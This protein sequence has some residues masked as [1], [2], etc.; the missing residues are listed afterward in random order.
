MHSRKVLLGLAVLAITAAAVVVPLSLL[1]SAATVPL[2]GS[3]DGPANPAG[4]TAFAAKT[5]ATPSIYSDYL[6]GSDGWPV[7]VGTKGASPWVLS[8]LTGK[9][10][11]SRLVLSVPLQDV[12]GED[13]QQSL[14]SYAANPSTWDAEFTILAQNLVADGFS[15]AIIRLMWEPDA[16]G[17][18]TN[19]D[20]TSAANYATV[21]RDAYGAMAS[22]AG[23]N[24]EWAWYWAAGFD[25]TTNNTAYP[26]NAYVND[27]TM[28]FY[29][30]SWLSSCGIAYNGSA[31]SATQEACLWSA[32]NGFAAELRGLSTFAAN[33]QKPMAFGEWGV[34]TRDDNHGGGDDPTFINEFS[35]WVKANNVAWIS[36]FD[37]NSGG[38]SVLAD[39]PNSL[40]AYKVDLGAS[41]GSPTPATTTTTTPATTTTTPATTTTTPATTTTTLATTTTTDPTPATTTTTDPT[42]T[43]T[44][45][46]P[47]TTTTT[48]PATTTTTD[49]TPAITA[50]TDPTRT[51]TTTTTTDPTPTTNI[52]TT[53]GDGPGGAQSSTSSLDPLIGGS[54]ILS[55]WSTSNGGE[56][57]SV[58]GSGWTENNDSSVT[59]EECAV[60]YYAA[61]SCDAS[62]PVGVTLGTRIGA[63]RF[64]SAI[65]LATGVIDAD[66]DTCGL[67]T[68]AQCYVVVVG[69]AGDF[70][71]SVPL[72]FTTPSRSAN[73]A[74]GR[75]PC[76]PLH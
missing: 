55:R 19:D 70:T 20:L 58:S 8:Q 66:N 43:T 42:P 24:F 75:Q 59:I 15:N 37:F 72:S 50:A 68:S 47:A 30:Q 62:N 48:T 56:A 46:T 14:A 41:G 18:Y 34:I 71:A 38:N 23:A 65:T 3:Y 6:Q 53:N 7:E 57:V 63:G 16:L 33:V 9:L 1:S 45:T 40:A 28:D 61:A 31:F 29:D 49:P 2:L 21:W 11:S 26:G 67:A 25:A 52:S 54:I 73:R 74:R 36:Y 32:P 12:T 69:N 35:A 76:E 4:V 39:Y 17:T 10:G 60:A 13:N 5:G 64:R 22:V 51:T 44:T 27:V